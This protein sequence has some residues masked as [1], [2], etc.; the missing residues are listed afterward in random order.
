M[1]RGLLNRALSILVLTLCACEAT[2]QPPT[3]EVVHLH[4]S[5]YDQGKQ[6]GEALKSKIHSFY[7]T[8]LTASLFPSLGREQADI[9]TLLKV[10]STEQ[11]Q[12]G[13]F[14]FEL[15]LDSALSMEK[16]L[17]KNHRDEL[18]GIADG[19]GL[20]Y[21]EV[22]VLNT[23]VDAVLAVRGVA[24]A[25]RLSRA[26]L[27][28]RLELTGCAT[29]GVDNNGDGMIDEANEGITD[30]FLA[31]AFANAVEVPVDAAIKVTLT[32][33][34]GIDHKALR[35]TLDN[36]L[37]TE[38]SPSVS[39][40]SPT[41]DTAI[42]TLKPAGGLSPATTHTLVL[43][44]GD[45]K[46]IV[47]P[48]PD[49]LSFMRD[50]ELLFTTKGAGLQPWQVKRPPLTDGRTR[51]PPIAFG[52]T[53]GAAADG[54]TL[55]AHHFA[56]LD[57]S[58]A[59]KHTVVLVHHPDD[60]SPAYATVG[61]AGVAFGFA[62]MSAR[63]VGYACNPSDSLD[64]SV[65]GSVIDQVADLTTAKLIAK[66]SPVGFVGRK[67]I[68]SAATADDAIAL[69]KANKHAYGWNCMVADG[70]GA[71]RIA[72]VDSDVFKNGDSV[73]TIAPQDLDAHGER[74]ASISDD[75]LIEGSAYQL[76]TTDVITLNLA[77][78][79]VVPQKVWSSFFYRSKRVVD[80]VARKLTP[81]MTVEDAEKLLG[82]DELVDKS[83]S[84]TAAVLDLTGKKLHYAIGE[85]PATSAPWETL[86]LTLAAP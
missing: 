17:S 66:G 50:E 53:G 20:S 69:F 14:A 12:N 13:H 6:H 22:L 39:I 61:W 4:G 7:T 58:T 60:G 54:L 68:E 2:K 82:D 35:L 15:L 49:H 38:T 47:K 65:V 79:R 16:S 86:D 55:L 63:G 57:A 30:P 78:Q 45:G 34:D 29:D 67:V 76:N 81:K 77:G 83:D 1:V 73:F 62:G 64:N 75:T 31:G 21:N 56:L 5:A 19:S 48:A 25:I 26:P 3:R 41:P 27:L 8:L 43:A 10:Y 23:F 84:M 80:A 44:A 42:V 70:K 33:P 85:V 59:H 71:M 36:V 18:H 37:Y 51:P 74:I 32:D 24:L 40:E 9:S 52:L 28:T 46:V 72:E 11:Y